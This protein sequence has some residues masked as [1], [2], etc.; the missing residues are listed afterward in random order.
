MIGG[1]L[2]IVGLPG[3]ELDPSSRETLARVRPAGVILFRRNVASPSQLRSLVAAVREVVPDVLLMVDAEGGRVDRLA[4]VVGAAP[5][6]AALAGKGEAL[7]RRAGHWIGSSLAAFDCD[8]DLAPVVDLDRGERNNALFERTW[9]TDPETVTTLAA[10]FLEGLHAAGV[11]GCVKHFPGL[12]AAR[13]DTHH[14]GS[15][16]DLDPDQAARH[17]EP[18]RFLAGGAGAVMIGHAAY[19]VHDASGHPAS[20]SRA[21]ATDLLRGRLGFEGVTISDDLEMAALAPI[22][23]LPERAVAAVEAGCDLAAVCARLDQ[24]E[25]VALALELVGASR[26]LEAEARIARWRRDIDELRQHRRTGKRAL[27]RAR[28]GLKRLRTSIQG[29]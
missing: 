14:H 12:G 23:G 8:V 27:G 22:G 28:A 6:A 3:L 1:A 25:A 9:G 15:E 2:M 13:E 10:A 7:A 26:R 5:S 4:P 29:R 18:F 20:V 11:A 16:I 24:A 19:P 21:I 17:L